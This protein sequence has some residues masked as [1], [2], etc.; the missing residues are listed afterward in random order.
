MLVSSQDRDGQPFALVEF[1]ERGGELSE[2]L[3][4]LKSARVRHAPVDPTSSSMSFLCFPANV[5]GFEG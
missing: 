3:L 1:K 5:R 2:L 4:A